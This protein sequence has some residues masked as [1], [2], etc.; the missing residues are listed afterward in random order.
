MQRTTHNGS[1]VRRALNCSHTHATITHKWECAGSRCECNSSARTRTPP[2]ESSATPSCNSHVSGGSGTTYRAAHVA[3][4]KV[5]AQHMITGTH[6]NDC[7][8]S[9][10]R[11]TTLS[12]HSTYSQWQWEARQDPCTQTAA[13]KSQLSLGCAPAFSSHGLGVQ[14]PQP[15]TPQGLA[16]AECA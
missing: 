3:P 12:L 2:H 4:W 16:Q 13:A 8:A 7:T 15:L 6:E 14:I 10:I 1:H 9:Q 5:Q 11:D